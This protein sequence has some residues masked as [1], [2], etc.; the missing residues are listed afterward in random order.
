MFPGLQGGPLEHV[1]AAKAVAFGEA[2]RP[3][4]KD[5]GRQVIRN[6]S[7][8][9]DAL[10]AEGFRLVAGGTDTHLVLVDLRGFDTELTGRPLRKSSTGP[11]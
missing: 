10:V 6:A 5:Y 4:F 1:I 2:L 7:A 11:A 9:A 3:E 8:F